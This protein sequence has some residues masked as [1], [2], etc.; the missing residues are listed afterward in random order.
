M[1]HLKKYFI[2]ISVNLVFIS[3]ALCEV[4]ENQKVISLEEAVNISLANNPDI[5]ISRT[6]I[7]IS[8][9]NLKS[10]KSALYP[11]IE[12]RI[13]IP[14]VEAES[15]FFLDQLIWDFGRTQNNIRERRFTIESRKADFTNTEQNIIKDTKLA[16]FEALIAKN[17]VD[18]Q[19]NLLS[20]SGL[21]LERTQELFNAGVSSDSE[22]SQA[23]IDLQE[24]R[25]NYLDSQNSYEIAK[26]NLSK[27]MGK[28]I[29]SDFDLEDT[30]K[31]ENIYLKKNELVE[32]AKSS[33]PQIK[34]I[35][36]QQ[37]GIKSR[38]KSSKSNFF[39]R[40]FGR[41]AYRFD[42]EGA[43]EPDFIAGIGI[44]LP[45]FQGFSR[46]AEI[47][48]SNAELQRSVAELHALKQN[49][50]FSVEELYLELQNLEKRIAITNESKAIAENSLKLAENRFDL[51]RASRIELSEA[52]SVMSESLARH[53]NTIYRYK[54]AKIKLE[55]LLGE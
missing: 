53:R 50:V 38:L 29:T 1:F 18:I 48:K 22:L 34:S 3:S 51:K 49:I 26:L 23:Q 47:N 55:S 27:I 17:S 5:E 43:D 54:I 24:S 28:E 31:Y 41:V 12:S 8:K 13:V 30:E 9:A 21:I 10:T 37:A 42:G 6:E 25:L 14:F 36:S 20:T 52:K 44:R 7:D 15:G 35:V 11:Q 16:Y 2:I 4:T 19:N 45:I 46:F 32:L 39:P 40:I 33:N